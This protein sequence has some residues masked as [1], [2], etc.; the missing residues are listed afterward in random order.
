MW[1]TNRK[2]NYSQ[3]SVELE[4]GHTSVH[5]VEVD[6][7]GVCAQNDQLIPRS[8]ILKDVQPDA[9]LSRHNPNRVHSVF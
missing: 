6:G 4:H 8:D 1:Y 3:N 2:E 7:P 5:W 9:S